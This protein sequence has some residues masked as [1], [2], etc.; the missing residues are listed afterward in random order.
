MRD[1]PH[2]S[3]QPPWHP[4]VAPGWAQVPGLPVRTLPGVSDLWVKGQ[5]SGVDLLGPSPPGE[6]ATHLQERK[7]GNQ[8]QT[9]RRAWG[10]GRR[11]GGWRP[12]PGLPPQLFLQVCDTPAPSIL[13]WSK[14]KTNVLYKRN[15]CVYVKS[16]ASVSPDLKPSLES[17]DPWVMETARHRRGA[18]QTFSFLTGNQLVGGCRVENPPSEWG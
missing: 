1:G 9:S 13:T 14:L 15:K 10:E 12:G 17:S 18:Y 5:G 8:G 16:E 7:D 4:G 6:K 2:Q 11:P 3:E